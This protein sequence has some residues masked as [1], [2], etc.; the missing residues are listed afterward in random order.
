MFKNFQ[1]HDVKVKRAEEWDE[2]LKTYGVGKDCST[3][4]ELYCQIDTKLPDYFE[5]RFENKTAASN[6]R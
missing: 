6:V 1:Y 3:A 4:E 2:K 5:V